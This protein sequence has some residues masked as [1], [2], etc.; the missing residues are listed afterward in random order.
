[1]MRSSGWVVIGSIL[2]SACGVEE[3]APGAEVSEKS[4]LS[5]QKTDNRDRVTGEYSVTGTMYFTENGQTEPMETEDIFIVTPE[6]PSP[7]LGISFLSFGPCTT[8]AVMVGPRSFLT[9]PGSCT[10]SPAPG[11]SLTMSYTFG[12]GSLDAN[13]V[14]DLGIHSI[15][16]GE[17]GAGPVVIDVY[18][19]LSGSRLEAPAASAPR[20]QA[21]SSETGTAALLRRVMAG[22]R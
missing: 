16:T 18:S 21:G 1:M 6:G 5:E 19:E 8:P 7:Q 13:A 12:W 10:A 3:V 4:G 14:L 22:S 11:C 2:L 20:A 9:L 15:L 17:C